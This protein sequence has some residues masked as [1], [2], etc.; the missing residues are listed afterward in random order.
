VSARATCRCQDN[1]TTRRWIIRDDID[2]EIF[3][4]VVDELMRLVRREDERVA[5]LY[6]GRAILVPDLTAT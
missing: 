4:A 2:D 3:G 6:I 5:A 1:G